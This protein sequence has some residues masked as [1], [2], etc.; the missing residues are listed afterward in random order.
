MLSLTKPKWWTISTDTF[1][2]LCLWG[3]YPSSYSLCW[4]SK[5]GDNSDLNCHRPISILPCRSKIFENVVNK[6]FTYHLETHNVLN[7]AQSGFRS[8]HICIKTKLKILNDIIC[9]TDNKHDCVATFSGFRLSGLLYI[10]DWLRD[11]W[12][13]DS[14]LAWFKSFYSGRLQSVRVRVFSLIFPYL[15]GS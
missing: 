7:Q 9:A 12:L 2:K 6:Q 4:I 13:S 11:I 3:Q 5:G 10:A 14:C 15:S 8:G 1:S